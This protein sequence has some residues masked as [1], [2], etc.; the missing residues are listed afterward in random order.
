MHVIML[1]IRPE[2]TGATL[3]LIFITTIMS[4]EFKEIT[5]EEVQQVSIYHA[6]RS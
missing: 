1:S 2:I 4:K 5:R 3:A 6:Y